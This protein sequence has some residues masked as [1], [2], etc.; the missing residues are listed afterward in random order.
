[1][2]S[3]RY[4]AAATLLASLIALPLARLLARRR[5]P[6]SDLLDAA[7]GLPSIFPPAVLAYSLTAA[8]FSWNA[9]LVLSVIWTALLLVRI[10]RADLEAVDHSF[11]NAA[12]SLGAGEWRLFW[13]VSVPLG[14]RALTTAVLAGFAR[15]FADFGA[16]MVVKDP[17]G[18]GWL[19][20]PVAAAALA[21]L[22]FGNRMRR[23][24]VPA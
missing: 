24:R 7:A 8:R 10:F 4:A 17:A 21:A 16:A 9:A 14:W 2:L 12:R 11:E 22:Y 18:T 13:R 20:A 23:A 5:F 15:A 6:G 19:I 1:M 3:L